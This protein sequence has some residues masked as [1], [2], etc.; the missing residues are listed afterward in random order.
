M[1]DFV[2]LCD[3]YA[4]LGNLYQATDRMREMAANGESYF[5]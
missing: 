1:A 5:G 4:H 2:A 3:K